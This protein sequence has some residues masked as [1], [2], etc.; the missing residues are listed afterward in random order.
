MKLQHFELMIKEATKA[1][2]FGESVMNK[3]WKNNLLDRGKAW[4]ELLEKLLQGQPADVRADFYERFYN[5]S[6]KN[7]YVSFLQRITYRLSQA[8]FKHSV[9][10]LEA[11]NQ[12]KSNE[13]VE[14]AI[15][16][17]KISQQYIDMDVE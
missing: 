16:F 8:L 7:L 10:K 14:R 11:K 12:Q 5:K 15:Q 6:D 4:D 17:Y 3:E 2:K 9:T 1:L 13:L